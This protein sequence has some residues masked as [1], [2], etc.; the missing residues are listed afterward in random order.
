MAFL[1]HFLKSG[2]LSPIYQQVHSAESSRT[3][4]HPLP[5]NKTK[6]FEKRREEIIYHQAAT[7]RMENLQE[8]CSKARGR[9]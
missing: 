9:D 8:Q 1:G 4:G 2:P 3:H 5:M 6:N 7:D